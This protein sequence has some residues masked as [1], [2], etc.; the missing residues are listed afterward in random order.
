MARSWEIGLTPRGGERERERERE[1]KRERERAGGERRVRERERERERVK[2]RGR[3]ASVEGRR[4]REQKSTENVRET[5]LRQP[6]VAL[7]ADER[8]RHARH[9]LSLLT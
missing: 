2:G 6:S 4:G 3:P 8:S 1:R 7:P 9:S 5:G